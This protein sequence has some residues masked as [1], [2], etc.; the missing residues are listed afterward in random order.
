MNK[1]ILVFLSIILCAF[2]SIAQTASLEVVCYVESS[3]GS[4][5]DAAKAEL[6]ENGTKVKTATSDSKGVISFNLEYG[7]AYKIVVTKQGMIQK[8]ID[9]KTEVSPEFQRNLRKEFA[10]S[11]VEN[12]DGADVSVF[13][14]PVDFIQYDAGFGN[15]VSDKAYADKMQSRFA[16]AYQGLEKCKQDKFQE[17]KL[18]ADKAFSEGNFEE[19]IK[20]YEEALKVFPNDAGVKRQIAQAQK[21]IT[22]QQS[23]SARYDQLIKEGDQFLVQNNFT[24]AKQRYAEAQKINPAAGYPQQKINEINNQAAQQQADLQKQQASNQAYNDYMKQGNAALAAKNYPLAQQMFEKA[25]AAKPGDLLASQKVAESQQMLKKQQQ[26]MAEQERINTAY[27]LALSNADASM[28]QTDYIKAQEYLQAAIALKPNETLPRQKLAEAQKLEVQKQQKLQAEQKAEIERKYNEAIANA[29]SLLAQSK[30]DEAKIAYEQALSLKPADPFAQQ[31]I[32][33]IKNL[34][35]EAQ[36]A[37]KATIEKQ[38]TQDMALGESKKL[39]KEY[40]GAITVF[41]QALV[42]KPND[43]QALSKVAES[44]KLL[45][46]QRKR[47]KEDQEIRA[48]YN[49]LIQEGDGLFQAKSYESSKVKYQE[50]LQLYPTEIYPRNQVAT[51]ENLLAGLSKEAEYTKIIT[52]GDQL[53]NQQN[54][55]GARAKYTQAQTVMPEKTYPAKKLNE[56]NQKI[57]EQ[58]KLAQLSKYNELAQQA[59]MQVSQKNYEQAKTLYNQAM[60]VMPENTYPQKRINEINQLISNESKNAVETRYNELISQA[61]QETSKKNYDVAKN[62]FGQAQQV[63]PEKTYPQQRINEINKMISD[64]SRQQLLES[65][66]KIVAEADQQFA[67]KSYDMAMQSYNRALATMPEQAYPQQKLNEISALLTELLRQQTEQ[68]GIES[69]YSQT[70]SLADRYFNEKSYSFATTEYNKA[71]QIKPAE[72]YPVQQIEK[73]NQLVSEQQMAEARMRELEAKYKESMTKADAMFKVRDYV[74]AKIVYQ[75]ALNYK[76]GDALA[77]SQIKRIDQLANEEAEVGN[78]QKTKQEQYNA[79]IASGDNF[80]AAGELSKAK[81]SYYSALELIPGQEYPRNQIR[82]IDEA[83]RA[84]LAKSE[85]AKTNNVPAPVATVV[86]TNAQIGSSTVNAGDKAQTKFSSDSERDRYLEQLKQKYSEGVTKE[87]YSD[88]TSSTTRYVI[89]R[90]GE[91]KEFVEVRFKWGGA[92][93]TYNGKAINDMYFNSQVKPRQGES[94]TEIKK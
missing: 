46:E 28:S 62:I 51:I 14:E 15:F 11:L 63:M 22:S 80:Y 36:Q 7:K 6:F 35:I 42:S 29:N 32:G 59:E 17:E 87:T 85:G 30:Y 48:R 25:S 70:I 3:T 92:E 23:T 10:M 88:N 67:S 49:Q 79:F 2:Q 53:F 60:L 64:A 45:S 65:Y 38:Y 16:S 4:P 74:N 1:S 57:N 56:I 34:I 69:Q 68:Q 58:A 19:S 75:D 5:I 91:V 66:N 33:K 82:K 37:Q 94:Y 73:I 71:R 52:E 47:E 61:E 27:Q 21:N 20:L 89:I 44:E 39:Q 26:D 12:C 8:R 86:G 31:Q 72:V 18:A 55:E 54:W 76:P 81:Q 40:Q 13:S 9:F 24:A 43:P 78:K 90:S 93:F 84:S 50:A 77:L 83:V 41:Q